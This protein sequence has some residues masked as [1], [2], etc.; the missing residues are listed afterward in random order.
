MRPAVRTSKRLTMSR[1]EL[2]V[3]F[4]EAKRIFEVMGPDEQ[5]R[6]LPEAQAT[7]MR[8]SSCV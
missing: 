8:L 4:P 5:R 7:V 1:T 3:P 6:I 2:A